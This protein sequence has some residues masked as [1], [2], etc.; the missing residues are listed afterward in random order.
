MQVVRIRVKCDQAR[1]GEPAGPLSA[2][3]FW[4]LLEVVDGSLADRE[5]R[6]LQP[7]DTDWVQSLIEESFTEL[8][9]EDGELLDDWKLDAPVLILRQV[10][11]AW[12]DRLL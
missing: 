2:K 7:G 9:C 3:Y 11:E 8:A 5:Y 1:N 6:V 10:G 4:E 12:D